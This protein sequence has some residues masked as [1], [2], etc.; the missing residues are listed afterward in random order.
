MVKELNQANKRSQLTTKQDWIVAALY[1][2]ASKS[3]SEGQNIHENAEM[4][5]FAEEAA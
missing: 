4:K 5:S 1:K 2:L 3:N